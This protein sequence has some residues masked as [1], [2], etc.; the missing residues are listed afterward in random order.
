MRR[1]KNT[2]N[3]AVVIEE[4][5]AEDQTVKEIALKYGIAVDTIYRWV[6]AHEAK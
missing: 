2:K 4:Y 6:R 1:N 3:K 5:Y